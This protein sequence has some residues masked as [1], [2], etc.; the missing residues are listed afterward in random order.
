LVRTVAAPGALLATF[1]LGAVLE[2]VVDP[3]R[4]GGA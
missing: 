2:T 4:L 1:A 3:D